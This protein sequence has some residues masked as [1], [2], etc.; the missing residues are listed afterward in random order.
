VHRDIKPANLLFDDD[1]RLVIAD[2]GLARALAE[3]AWTEPEGT[4]LGTARYAAPE[5][6]QGGSVGGAAD[7]YALSLVMVEAVTGS[8]PFAADTTIATLMARVDND[9]EPPES[10]GALA[11]VV[12]R[13]GVADP[14]TRIDAAELVRQLDRTARDLPTPAPLPLTPSGPASGLR[15]DEMTNLGLA[16]DGDATTAVSA[17]A[18]GRPAPPSDGAEDRGARTGRGR[19]RGLIALAVAVVLMLLLG[20][21]YAVA[22]ARIPTHPV[23]S[24]LGLDADQARVAAAAEKLDL[25]V[26]GTRYQD[27][28]EPGEVINQDPAPDEELKEGRAV[29]VILSKGPPPVTV[30]DLAGLSEEQARAKLTAAGFQIV[31]SV[32]RPYDEVVPEGQVINW[33]G[34][35]TKRPKGSNIALTVSAGPEPVPVPNLFTRVVDEFS[36][37]LRSLG[38]SIRTEQAFSDTVEAGEIITTKPG[39]GEPAKKNSEVT[40]VVSKG[41][42]MIKVPDVIGASR[43]DAKRRLEAA[44]LKVGTVYGPDEGNEVF[45]TSPSKGTEVKRGTPVD[46]YVRRVA[47]RDD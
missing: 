47:K 45:H 40:L 11:P 6:V 33:T 10:L 7:V 8:V 32:A 25:K 1:G 14:T 13:A 3:A 46:L 43:A 16:G 31:G 38:F 28:T 34:K 15:D 22:Q 19:R 35:G 29:E 5:Q 2:F 41:P 26:A 21:G 42:E 44:G 36:E 4:V 17:T 9:L 18:G 39:P 27:D 30:P 23:P 12:A 24:V 37:R 20:G